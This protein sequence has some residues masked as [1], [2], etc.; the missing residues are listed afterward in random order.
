MKKIKYILLIANILIFTIFINTFIFYN[1][2]Y[3]L[4]K[5]LKNS[6]EEYISLSNDIKKYSKIKEEI[7]IINGENTSLS[8]KVTSL[9]SEIDIKNSSIL[10]YQNK[11]S[12]LNN[13]ISIITNTK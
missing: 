1:K 9:N 4:N 6:K 12:D 10:N 13:K 5:S 11:I 2:E 7:D 3:K 8:D